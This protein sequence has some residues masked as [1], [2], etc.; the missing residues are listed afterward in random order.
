MISN[1]RIVD[2]RLFGVGRSKTGAQWHT[3][4]VVYMNDWL[5]KARKRKKTNEG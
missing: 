4:F 5:I 2:D 1:S 3:I